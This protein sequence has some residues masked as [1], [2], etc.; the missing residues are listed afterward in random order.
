MIPLKYF[1]ATSLIPMEGNL[2][3]DRVEHDIW[4]ACRDAAGNWLFA[5]VASYGVSSVLVAEIWSM[6][7]GL[8]LAY[9]RGYRRVILECDNLTA[10]HHIYR[11]A[12]FSTDWLAYMAYFLPLGRHF[13]EEPSVSILSWLFHNVVGVSYSRSAVA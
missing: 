12:N 13:L 4:G 7:K 8:R 10:I 11:E 9:D 3:G 5:F 2:H 1:N 6:H